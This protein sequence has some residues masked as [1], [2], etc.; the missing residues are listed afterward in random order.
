VGKNAPALRRHAARGDCGR[1]VEW[2]GWPGAVS[3]PR[4]ADA[5]C[6][7]RNGS[8]GACGCVDGRGSESS[9]GVQ[10]AGR[11]AVSRR[12]SAHLRH[13][14]PIVE[15][16]LQ[17]Q[18]PLDHSARCRLLSGFHRRLADAE[19]SRA[20]WG[21]RVSDCP[22]R[23]G[24]C[25]HTQR[26]GRHRAL[27]V[28]RAGEWGRY[29]CGERELLAGPPVCRF[30]RDSRQPARARTVAGSERGTRRR[31]GGPGGR[32]A[33]GPAAEAHRCAIAAGGAAG[34]RD[35]GVRRAAEFDAARV[36]SIAAHC[37]T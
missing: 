23:S 24:Q 31:G 20:S 16:F 18:L 17:R 35:A 37:S 34:A 9:L 22:S 1:P 36:P 3:G 13:C 12:F 10:A 7:R 33:R 19:S 29:A 11:R 30:H 28:C 8:P 14:C 32:S 21:R 4:R 6:Q 2:P 26:C 25:G 15:P 5:V 27:P